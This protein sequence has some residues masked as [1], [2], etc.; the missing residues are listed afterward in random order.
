MASP[1]RRSL[2][3]IEEYEKIARSVLSQRL[4]NYIFRATESETTLRR[5]IESFSR[6][7]LRR[8][9][10]QEIE[11]VET[12]TSYFDGRIKSSLPFFPSCINIS[13]MYPK[14]LLDVLAISKSYETPIFISDLAIERYFEVSKLPSLVPKTSSLVWQ[15]YFRKGNEDLCMK[16]AKLAK[17][18][19]YKGIAVTVDVELNVKL[20]YGIPNDLSSTQFVPVTRKIVRTLRESTSLPLIVKG[21]MVPEDAELAVELGADGIVV[22]N[23]G[24]RI[25]DEG[26]ATLDVLPEIVRDLKSKRRYRRAEVFFDG[27]IRKGTDIL[28]ALA[29]GA[30]GCLI[31]RPIFWGLAVNNK[32]GPLD[33]MRILSEELTRAAALCGVASIAKVDSSVLRTAP[34]P[35]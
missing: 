6:Y 24:G 26:E 21:I 32:D 20:G 29:L 12:R 34:S 4:I 8:R 11:S 3:S 18:W 7:A 31:G 14:A 23:H 33:I 13:P 1:K 25:L 2:T 9:V 16:Q 5:N 10:L 22:S 19:G 27:G 17:S 35:N 28:K 30:K 15:I